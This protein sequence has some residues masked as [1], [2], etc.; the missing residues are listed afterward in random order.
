MAPNILELILSERQIAYAITNRDFVIQAVHGDANLLWGDALPSG[1]SALGQKLTHLVPELAASEEELHAVTGGQISHLRYQWVNR[2]MGPEDEVQRYVTL[3]V[4]PYAPEEGPSQQG[5]LLYLVQDVTEQGRLQQ[6]LM[7]RHNEL[8]LLKEQL[9]RRN[10]ELAAANAE[11]QLMDEMRAAFVSLTAHELRTPLTSIYGYLELLLDEALGPLTEEQQES[12]QMMQAG[13]EH[14][15]TTV[16]NLVDVVR[17]D[18]DRIELVLQP[19]DA[20]DLVQ[21][22]VDRFSHQAQA[23]G[24]QVQVY[25]ADDLPLVLCDAVRAKQIIGHLLS[26]AIRLT[27]SNAAITVRVGADPDRSFLQV[28]VQEGGQG[29]N[30]ALQA[31]L[32]ERLSHRVRDGRDNGGDAGLGLYLTRALVDLHG[33]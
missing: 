15:L 24:Q 18:S 14:L 3:S 6:E 19:M 12:L 11:L 23:K 26:T 25:F 17:L 28:S 2:S 16:T 20:R 9:E 13:A 30:P 8:R 21:E 10:N 32:F 29:G 33:G 22:T 4:Q 31:Q 27:P 1:A 5:G 7:Q